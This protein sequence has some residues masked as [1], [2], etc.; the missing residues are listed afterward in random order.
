MT[1][2]IKKDMLIADIVGEFPVAAS[3]MMKYGLHCVGCHISANE[4]LEQGC[5]GHGLDS[6]KI[7]KMVEEINKAIEEQNNAPVSNEDGG[8]GSEE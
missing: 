4:T 6:E 1:E 7:D 3:I 8:E 2:H 5:M